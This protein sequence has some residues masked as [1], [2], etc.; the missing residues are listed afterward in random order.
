MTQAWLYLLPSYSSLSLSG[1]PVEDREVRIS[2][3]VGPGSAYGNCMLTSDA[4]DCLVFSDKVI[5]LLPY[6]FHCNGIPAAGVRGF[7]RGDTAC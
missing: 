6:R 5:D 1:R 3:R 4:D 2:L 7:E